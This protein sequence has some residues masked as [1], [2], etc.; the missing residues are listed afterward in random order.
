MA[1]LLTN[2]VYLSAQDVKDTTQ[3]TTLAALTD[4]VVVRLIDE[5]QGLVDAFLECVYGTAYD[6]T[7]T[8][9]YPIVDTS[10]A[11][12]IPKD[13]RLA[14][15]YVVEHLH[16]LGDP[17]LDSNLGRELIVEKVGD[18]SVEYSESRGDAFM[19]EKAMRLLASYRKTN[20]VASF[21]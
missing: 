12:Y 14:T 11:S 21:S 6:P 8:T 18:H 7:Q 5:A 13:V 20:F 3:L 1:N 17:T 15:L 9:L 19:P 4:A 2:A 10:G 16:L